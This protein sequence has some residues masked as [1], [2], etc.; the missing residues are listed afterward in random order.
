MKEKTTF[1]IHSGIAM[2]DGKKARGKKNIN[3]LNS[4]PF[5]AMGV[6]DCI[7]CTWYKD[8]GEG[9]VKMRRYGNAARG[10]NKKAGGKYVFAV[11]KVDND[12]V[13]ANKLP[14]QTVKKGGH[15]LLWR[16]K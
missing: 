9:D 2:P 10:W 4:Y 11:R 7:Y 13:T 5:P 16:T 12:F 1:K 14:Y 15:I 3:Q 8:A 6:G